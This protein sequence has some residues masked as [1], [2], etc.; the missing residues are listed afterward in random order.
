MA[1]DCQAQTT[2]RSQEVSKPVVAA[3]EV[4]HA[5]SDWGAVLLKAI[6]AK[7]GPAAELPGSRAGRVRNRAGRRCARHPFANAATSEAS[8]QRGRRRG[9]APSRSRCRV[10]ADPADAPGARKAPRHDLE[11]LRIVVHQ[12]E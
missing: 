12:H 5:S 1:T 3:F 2:F 10:E 4:A 6:D 7:V 8:R 9:A 11:R